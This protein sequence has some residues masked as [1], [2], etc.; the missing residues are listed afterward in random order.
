M[1][2]QPPPSR[3]T[4]NGWALVPFLVFAVFY[5]GLSIQANDFYKVPMPIAFLVASAAAL[6]LGRKRKLADKIDIYASSMGNQ[7]IMIMCLIFIL[8][9]AFATVAKGMGAVDAA[10]AI[11]QKLIPGQLMLAGMFLVSSL[12]SLSI[13]TSCGT[14]AAIIP[15][16]AGLVG[17]MKI[18]P[19]VMIGAV[20]SG[21][22]FGDNLSMISDTTIAATR[23]QN[24]PMREKFLTNIR[25]VF[26]VAILSLL[27][28][29][30]LG[31]GNVDLPPVTVGWNEI[32][33]VL[34]YVLILVLALLGWNVMLLLFSGTLLACAI[35]IMLHC[36]DFWKS[37]ELIGKG[38]L[39]MS[40]TLIVAILAGGLLGLIR[41][42]GGI[43]WLMDK[44]GKMVHGPRGCEFGVLL[45]VSAVN[46]F[47]ANNTVAIIIAGPVARSLSERFGCKPERIASILDTG[48]CV[49]QGVIPYGAQLLMAVSLAKASGV[50]VPP[51]SLILHLYYQEMLVIA[52]IIF[53]LFSHRESTAQT[54]AN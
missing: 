16:A 32:I 36:F 21:A 33:L 7:N 53:I 9:G 3:P 47:T 22:M 51:F 42:N 35:G 25:I 45:L 10:V 27:L 12:I 5:V 30:L 26:P 20:V 48:S 34:P 17:P 23:T 4:A 15:I 46:L 29:A 50:A 49:I 52:V 18:D 11:A 28:Y 19:A 6:F 40:E 31:H 8:S 39:G 38:T 14:I 54:I 24:I 43:T 44:I 13:G 41:H 2:N 1:S 37:L